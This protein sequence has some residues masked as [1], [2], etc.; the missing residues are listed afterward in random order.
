[1]SSIKSSG[2]PKAILPMPKPDKS[3]SKAE[4][5][6]EVKAWLDSLSPK[7]RK[8]LAYSARE[9]L[10]PKT[11]TVREPVASRRERELAEVATDLR[12]LQQGE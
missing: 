10:R 6:A 11:S 9:A 1:M 12:E 7:D 3:K 5:A 8:E 4:Q 2:E